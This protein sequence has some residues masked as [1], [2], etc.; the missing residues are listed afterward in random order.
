MVP[1]FGETDDDDEDED[2]HDAV[3]TT[4]GTP[5]GTDSSTVFWSHED[6]IGTTMTSPPL[7]MHNDANKPA[8]KQQQQQQYYGNNMSHDSSHF[9]CTDYS[10]NPIYGRDTIGGDNSLS[11]NNRGRQESGAAAVAPRQLGPLPPRSCSIITSPH[12]AHLTDLCSPLGG[13]VDN[14]RHHSTTLFSVQGP[15]ERGRRWDGQ[16]EPRSGGGRVLVRGDKVNS[17]HDLHLH[18]HHHG[19]KKHPTAISMRKGVSSSKPKRKP[20][21]LFSQTQVFELERKFQQQRYLSANERDGLAKQLKLTPNQVKIWFQNRRYKSKKC[22][23]PSPILTSEEVEL[24]GG[25]CDTAP[26]VVG[27]SQQ[28]QCVLQGNGANFGIANTYPVDN[29]TMAYPTVSDDEQ[30]QNR[31]M[32]SSTYT[33]FVPLSQYN[34][35]NNE[36][37]S[38]YACCYATNFHSNLSSDFRNCVGIQ[39]DDAAMLSSGGGGLVEMANS[40][41]SSYGMIHGEITAQPSNMLV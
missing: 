26:V 16:S 33:N 14:H 20:R 9:F 41:S 4:S 37:D 25:G 5:S 1:F 29:N 31:G 36:S 15:S 23:S 8:N 2:D 27:S 19:N 11:N 17:L 3:T 40:S 13:G 39:T 18:Q 24:V 7:L 28:Q 22:Q 34:N 10:T 32:I 21:V 6:S 12:L 38:T 30:S 35:Y